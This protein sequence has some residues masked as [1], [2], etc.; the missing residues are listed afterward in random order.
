MEAMIKNDD[1]K[2]WMTPLLE[3]RNEIGDFTNEAT[4]R[5]YRRMGGNVFLGERK[6][7]GEH[8]LVRGPYRP[9]WRRYY[10]R[11]LLEV[12]QQIR[13]IGPKDVKSIELISEAELHEIARI[14]EY[15]K[16]EMFEP[17]SEIYEEV[18]GE[19]LSTPS[20][21]DHFFGPEDLELL[22]EVAGESE[23][24]EYVQMLVKMLNVE[25]KYRGMARRA[26]I[27]DDLKACLKAAQFDSE[28]EAVEIRMEEEGRRRKTVARS[29]FE[30]ETDSRIEQV[31]S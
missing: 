27:F 12:Q 23:E 7:D 16:G 18:V 5:D 26:G 22:K 9:K 28:E 11:R 19:P 13:E 14:W 10:L 1:E 24:S 20:A 31:G 6:S 17:V 25:R 3:F 8:Y 21:D 2:V 4:R 29:L 30:E 15:D